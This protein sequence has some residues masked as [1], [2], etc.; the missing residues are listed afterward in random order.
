MALEKMRQRKRTIL[1]LYL[2]LCAL[3]SH[4]QDVKHFFISTSGKANGVGTIE[5]PFSSLENARNA[6]GK[7]LLKQKNVSMTVYFRE[8]NY[9]IK[10]SEVFDSLDARTEAYPVTYSAFSNELVSQSGGISKM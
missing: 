8:G 6:V 3:S 7:V 10:N 4:S 1:F 5:Q 2:L 9:A